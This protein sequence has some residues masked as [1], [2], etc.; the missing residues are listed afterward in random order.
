MPELRQS[1]NSGLAALLGNGNPQVTEDALYDRMAGDIDRT[2][3]DAARS[4]NE[5]TF[6]RGLG[7]STISRDMQADR[8]RLRGDALGKARKDAFL[9]SQQATLAALAQAAGVDARRQQ[10]QQQDQQFR[11][12]I[13]SRDDAMG[14]QRDIAN[15]QMLA[16]GGGL[17]GGSLLQLAGKTF[18]PEIQ[19]LL[20]NLSGLG[21]KDSEPTPTATAATVPGASMDIGTDVAMPS[22][23]LGVSDL[24]V[25]LP[26]APAMPD[27]DFGSV[28]G[29]DA[30]AGFDPFGGY[31]PYNTLDYDYW[32]M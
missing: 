4:I 30:L 27:F 6:G 2:S 26:D 3:A 25:S 18:A 24:D 9:A 10:M 7:L 21:G 16:Q 28:G 31:D 12:S 17:L 19:G 11:A 1:L 23:D 13:N 20:R 14:A 32:S 22:Y 8:E 29:L 15:N 5:N